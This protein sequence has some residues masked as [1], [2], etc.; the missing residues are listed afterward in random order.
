M[1]EQ[2]SNNEINTWVP[3]RVWVRVEWC[4][5]E[6]IWHVR[7][8]VFYPCSISQSASQC[9]RHRQSDVTTMFAFIFILYIIVALCC[10]ALLCEC[11]SICECSFQLLFRLLYL[12][13]NAPIPMALCPFIR[14]IWP[15]QLC[16]VYWKIVSGA[17]TVTISFVSSIY[18]R[19]GEWMSAI[20]VFTSHIY[21]AIHV[22]DCSKQKYKW[23]QHT[24]AWQQS[25]DFSTTFFFISRQ[26]IYYWLL[27]ICFM[28]CFRIHF[29]RCEYIVQTG[30][31]GCC[32][33]DNALMS[34]IPFFCFQ[35]LSSLV[36]V[37][38][39]SRSAYEIDAFT[40]TSPQCRQF[41]DNISIKK[42]WAHT[43]SLAC[44]RCPQCLC[45]CID[46][47]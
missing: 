45:I 8:V 29:I 44:A 33:K 23:Q 17:I 42:H 6:R 20:D 36:S 31:R 28:M 15:T 2:K 4:R 11:C 39:V 40:F 14:S 5:W 24:V 41:S 25:L 46:H 30:C 47:C 38:L 13:S 27:S 3:V 9:V 32:L 26:L 19:V 1:L 22:W 18:G 34:V 21:Q 35:S 16:C 7:R 10:V 37:S 12:L 43:T